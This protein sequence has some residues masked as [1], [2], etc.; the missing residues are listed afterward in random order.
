MARPSWQGVALAA[1]VLAL[2]T[3]V[4]APTELITDA[5]PGWTRFDVDN[6]FYD[7][8]QEFKA[9]M[10]RAFIE[11]YTKR[12]R[13]AG[14]LQS[15]V[16][17]LG[18]PTVKPGLDVSA[19]D[20]FFFE[21]QMYAVF[22][23]RTLNES[24]IVHVSHD[25]DNGTLRIE[26]RASFSVQSF[27]DSQYNA[28][29]QPSLQLRVV[30]VKAYVYGGK[31]FIMVGLMESL[32]LLFMVSD[33]ATSWTPK[34]QDSVL[35]Y[36]EVASDFAF[37]QEDGQLRVFVAVGHRRL[38][39]RNDLVP[40][41]Q[42]YVYRLS[43]GIKWLQMHT[44][45]TP[46]GASSVT[47]FADQRCTYIVIG[48]RSVQSLVYRHD[49]D[50]K[51][52]ELFQ[53]LPSRNVV[54]V[55]AFFHNTQTYVLL[56]NAYGAATIFWWTSD[57]L[58]EWQ[59]LDAG[60]DMDQMPSG[61]V[62]IF[63]DGES[64]V[65]IVRGNTI[66]FYTSFNSYSGHFS[67]AYRYSL[68]Q[69]AS[70]Q[71]I[72]VARVAQDS[73]Y[74][75]VSVSAQS[76]VQ[77]LVFPVVVRQ[78]HVDPQ[79]PEQDPLFDC[80]NELGEALEAL[81]RE[82]DQLLLLADT[83]FVSNGDRNVTAAI[84]VA[85]D[86]VI[87]GPVDIDELH[88]MSNF[89]GELS[90]VD[91]GDIHDEI[92]QCNSSIDRLNSGLQ[93]ALTVST[94]QTITGNYEFHHLGS[95]GTLFINDLSHIGTIQ[96][97]SFQD[98]L[99]FALTYSGDQLL[100]FPLTIP[101]G[102]VANLTLKATATV[103]GISPGDLMY[104]SGSQNVTGHHHYKQLG[105][106]GDL[107]LTGPLNGVDLTS[108]LR[109][110]QTLTLP[111][112]QLPAAS[113]DT[114]LVTNING[115]DL[116][117]W[118]R[119]LIR[120]DRPQTFTDS[121]VIS[122]AIF[123]GV[124]VVNLNGHH[125]SSFLRT[126]WKSAN[127]VVAG[128]TVFN[129]PLSV[130]HLVADLI[131][132]I[133]LEND[134]LTTDTDQNVTS[135]LQ[136]DVMDVAVNLFSDRVNGLD[137]SED[138]IRVTGGPGIVTGKVTF[139]GDLTVTGDVI[140]EDNVTI[141]GV[142]ISSAATLLSSPGSLLFTRRVLLTGHWTV[143]GSVTL[144]SVDGYRLADF[145]QLFW[146]V[147][148]DQE[149][150]SPV[151]I[152]DGFVVNGNL[153]VNT[154][155]GISTDKLINVQTGGTIQNEIIFVGNVTAA[156]VTL[157]PGGRVNDHDLSEFAPTVV[158]RGGDQH[159]SGVK[160][161]TGGVQA[162][163]I[164]VDT[165]NNLRVPEDILLVNQ[166]QIQTGS[167]TFLQDVDVLNEV[168]SSGDVVVTNTING[169]H[170][171]DILNLILNIWVNHT[172]EHVLVIEGDAHFHDLHVKETLNTAG[173]LELL[174]GL[175]NL[176]QDTYIPGVFTVNGN[177]LFG[178]QLSLNT[179]NGVNW[180]DYLSSL[181]LADVGG[182]VSGT[183]TLLSSLEVAAPARLLV[184][185]LN[186]YTLAELYEHHLTLHT[187]Q[188]IGHRT[189]VDGFLHADDLDVSV[190]NGVPLEQ[191]MF[192]DR[193]LHFYQSVHIF[194]D[195][196]TTQLGVAGG[197]IGACNLTKIWQHGLRKTAPIQTLSQ[198]TTIGSL[199]V[200]GDLTLS[201]NDDLLPSQDDLLRRIDRIVTTT[202]DHVITGN[203]TFQ[204][205]LVVT[206]PEIALYNG[207][208]VADLFE[209]A[210]TNSSSEPVTL[211]YP[212]TLT[213]A[214]ALGDVTVTSD[215]RVD[216]V[217]GVDLSRWYES[218]VLRT[219]N[220][221]AA[222][223]AAGAAGRDCWPRAGNR[224]DQRHAAIYMGANQR[225]HTGRCTL[226]WRTHNHQQF[227]SG[228]SGGRSRHPGSSRLG[229]QSAAKRHGSRRRHLRR[230]CHRLEPECTTDQRH[231]PL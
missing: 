51:H 27:I 200:N 66:Y 106:S 129:Q 123:S 131:N 55:K 205:P 207:L 2:A 50:T 117:A 181:V 132:G 180:D 46:H 14:V 16:E 144:V 195:V 52:L 85:S 194:S 25:A 20:L 13:D 220:R 89:S 163:N 167:L 102:S 32:T 104:V 65:Y 139:S 178:S 79:P 191:L 40:A 10:N 115:R 34:Y 126:L 169:Y 112:A 226:R 211:R 81:D 173:L 158:T 175:L 58:F 98:L 29:Y 1:L 127:D 69:G 12:K 23:Q 221:R 196:S 97:T 199:T 135:H 134:V 48:Q 151:T 88:I 77:W 84:T 91:L 150:R 124:H 57:Q 164:I 201:Q 138:V 224:P 41:H 213:G 101:S 87:S 68:Q 216:L 49:W 197:A 72:H 92:L 9:E 187:D 193:D 202:G 183:T 153:V 128:A 38:G 189:T 80:L 61:H 185:S 70:V 26:R 146:T 223:G 18:E 96:G 166:D 174:H 230:R 45:A 56:L 17:R 53:Y 141:N 116:A 21:G 120:L 177:V 110:G 136:L 33:P 160:T 182:T 74:L 137:L 188:V 176:D 147:D 119:D 15:Q 140:V 62:G 168:I 31:V 108:V 210:L 179:V 5:R 130:Q 217:N 186:G 209:N 149:I 152:R 170:V 111:A 154:I 103:N 71:H 171:D 157:P 212:L 83:V 44:V 155:N 75:L 148:G 133:D 113:V 145:D 60:S 229:R 121:L 142:D 7:K 100:Q 143:H 37:F 203:V 228:R 19:V 35:S 93:S 59:S 42:S 47:T 208:S 107:W 22:S 184:S 67:L 105:V 90:D 231:R 114:L 222:A 162:G 63:H 219:D 227:G 214:V 30:E 95:K 82:L 109:L 94:P 156:D 125:L 43:G 24:Y 218:L 28:T 190:V 225:H 3:D 8:E 36:D 172:T 206:S 76:A 73:Y 78:S 86:I 11:E 161:F 99:H 165:I 6:Y 4:S 204:R 159:I 122:D 118:Q 198:S 64:Y 54:S 215:A 39:Y 192:T